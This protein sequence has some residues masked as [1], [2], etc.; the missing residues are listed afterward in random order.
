MSTVLPTAWPSAL[1]PWISSIAMFVI[2]AFSLTA[3]SPNLRHAPGVSTCT[4]GWNA[5]GTP[6]RSHVDQKSS[7]T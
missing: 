7:Y 1:P 4:P 6:S 5:T 3:T 2:V